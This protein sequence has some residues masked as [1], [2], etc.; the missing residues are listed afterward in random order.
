MT[1]T[2]AV[3]CHCL[4]HH[5]DSHLLAFAVNAAI[6]LMDST[7]SAFQFNTFWTFERLQK[8]VAEKVDCFSVKLTYHLENDKAKEGST[9]IQSQEDFIHFMDCMCS[10][11]VQPKM[12]NG[13]PGRV[14]KQ[15]RVI[16]E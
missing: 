1:R 8:K 13:K 7:K 12:A 10:L 5:S 9:S 14:P 16:L 4:D 11:S 15:F 2:H 6:V 3:S